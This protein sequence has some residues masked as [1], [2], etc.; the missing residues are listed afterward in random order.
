MLKT[1]ITLSKRDYFLYSKIGNKYFEVCEVKDGKIINNSDYIIIKI[2]NDICKYKVIIYIYVPQSAVNI[3]IIV[4]DTRK[5]IST[6]CVNFSDTLP[7]LTNPIESAVY[8]SAIINKYNIVELFSDYNASSPTFLPNKF[9]FIL[10]SIK[11]Y[12]YLLPNYDI[13][14]PLSIS[15]LYKK[16]E[17]VK[18]VGKYIK[19]NKI[20]ELKYDIYNC[21]AHIDIFLEDNEI[22]DFIKSPKIHI[23]CCNK[24]DNIILFSFQ[25]YFDVI[26]PIDNFC[27]RAY[28]IKSENNDYSYRIIGNYPA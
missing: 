8:T 27:I 19:N 11:E 12:N 17:K 28:S 20:A 26:K 4:K 3:K 6:L 15:L 2:I 1:N 14:N 23:I 7:V 25:V 18:I 10:P 21:E 13:N 16:I 22:V 5:H 24:Y 9:E